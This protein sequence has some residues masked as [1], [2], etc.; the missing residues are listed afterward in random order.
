[1]QFEIRCQLGYSRASSNVFVFNVGVIQNRYQRILQESLQLDPP[2]VWEEYISPGLENRYLRVMVP[3]DT[4]SLD[5]QATVE[6]SPT[7]INPAT[8]P[9][10]PLSELPLEIFHYL[11]PSRY[12]ESD[13]LMR[14]VQQE[15]GH[16]RPGYTQVN[17]IC[18]W[19]HNNIT[20]LFGISDAHTSAYDIATKR[21]GVCRDFAHVGIAFCRALN[22][23]AR[24]VTAYAYGL[25]PSDFHAYF[26][27]YLGDHWY[28]FDPTRL[29]AR[30]GLIRIGTGQDAADV[31][32][33]TIFGPAKLEEMNLSVTLIP[34]YDPGLL[35]LPELTE[36]I[37]TSEFV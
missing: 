3:G 23:P 7:Y 19:I 8:I 12:C 6:L 25:E 30:S 4:L 10:I 37:V 26:E 22:I 5:Y 28:L 29:V 16:L 27:A 18:D 20:Y 24:F 33:A 36:A 9:E 15:F 34:R 35:K 1:M 2:L 11:Y 13:R 21:A 31:A 32:F 17:A 14:L